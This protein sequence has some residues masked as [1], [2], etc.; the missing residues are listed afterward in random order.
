[1]FQR[2]QGIFRLFFVFVLLRGKDDSKTSVT[3][4][5]ASSALS[6]LATGSE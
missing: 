3:E 5:V 6:S 4:A 2:T 1:M